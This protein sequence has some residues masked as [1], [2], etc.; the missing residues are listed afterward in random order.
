MGNFKG[1]SACNSLGLRMAIILQ[2]ISV[3]SMLGWGPIHT[4]LG[5]N[6]VV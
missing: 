2:A 5:L 6:L 4:L 1:K 3:T